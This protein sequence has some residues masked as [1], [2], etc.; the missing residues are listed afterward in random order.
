MATVYIKPGSGTGTG[1][2]ADPYFY[3]QLVTAETA[4]GN[5]GTIYFTDGDYSLNTGT[6]LWRASGVNYESLNLYGAK[7][8]Y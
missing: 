4:A 2:L 6:T 7:L 8:K 3:N 5:G 1:T